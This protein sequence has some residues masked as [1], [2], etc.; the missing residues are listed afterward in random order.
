LSGYKR[1]IDSG[2]EAVLL[3]T[4]PCF[5]PEH[6]RA[7]VDAGVHV[8]IAKP[9]AC[10][11][12]GTLSIEAT[13]KRATNK[14]QVFLVDFQ[15]RTDPLIIEGIGYLHN[16]DIGK[17]GLI[18]S[19]YADDGFKDPPRTDTIESRLT[20]LIWTNDVALGGGMLVN[21]GIHMLDLGLWM[22]QDRVPVAAMGASSVT[23]EDPHGDTA[24]L[25][26]LTYE[27]DNGVILNHRGDHLNNRTRFTTECTALCQ[28][29]YFKCGYSGPTRIVGQDT[30][31][32][33]GEIE[34]LYANG[35]RR[36]IAA[37]H[38][39]ITRGI[40]DNPTLAPSVNSTLAAIL[41]REAGR[42]RT[43]LTMKELIR[44]NRAL[45]VDLRGLKA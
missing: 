1:V 6:A 23:K 13:G 28:S 16:G 10:D 34:D 7:F 4:P 20:D 31:W 9:L 35:A 30:A 17:I 27:F 18:N 33:G 25:Y 5:F 22:N 15:T 29:G 11:V 3:E 19:Y 36:N 42:R 43:R 45:P 39:N 26:S 37:F 8:F 32:N 2:V 44:E 38:A 24:Y 12:P 41:G 14:G 40:H 21:A